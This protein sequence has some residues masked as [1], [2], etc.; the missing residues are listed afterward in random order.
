[1][2]LPDFSTINSGFLI[3]HN[4]LPPCLQR[5]RCLVVADSATA[6]IWG[7]GYVCHADHPVVKDFIPTQNPFGPIEFGLLRLP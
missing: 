4:G 5:F 2:D 1:M 3:C 6:A 7:C